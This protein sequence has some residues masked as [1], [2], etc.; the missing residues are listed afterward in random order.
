MYAEQATSPPKLRPPGMK[1]EK[2]PLD[3]P[4]TGHQTWTDYTRYALGIEDFGPGTGHKART[5]PKLRELVDRRRVLGIDF[6]PQFVGLAL[7]LGGV[8]TVPVGTLQ[9]GQDWTLVASKIAQIAS[10]RKVKDIVMGLPLE[11]TG[12]IGKIGQLVR[13]FSLILADAVLLSL[14]TS[15]TL[16]LW[17]ERFSTTYAAMR[18]VVRPR[19]DGHS[20]KTWLDGQK[21]LAFNA[22]SLLD[23][24]AARAILEHFVEVDP[25]TMKQNKE[26]AERVSPSREACLA[27]L[28]WKRAPMVSAKRPEEPAGP[29]GEGFVWDEEHPLEESMTAEEYMAQAAN[30]S[31]YMEGMDNFGDREAEYAMREA[32]RK[33]IDRSEAVR[34]TTLQQDMSSVKEKFRDAGAKMTESNKQAVRRNPRNLGSEKPR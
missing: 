28:Q 29:G 8:N 24:E 2:L 12:E 32:R 18:L 26:R 25:R 6:G 20:F 1:G 11:K 4:P 34:K 5:E 33:S 9:T 15:T 17:D 30:F 19:F 14:G 21:G 7:S 22:K 31:N 27:Y 13:H 10:T 16:Y 23:A 3:G